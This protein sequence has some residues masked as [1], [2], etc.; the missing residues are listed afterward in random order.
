MTSLFDL[1]G[2]TVLVTGGNGGLGLAFAT[3]CARHG[4]NI[5]IWGR[6]ARKNDEAVEVL[7]GYGVRAVGYVV[8]VT[9]EDVVDEAMDVVVAAFGRIDCVFANAGITTP[10][11][12]TL[13]LSTQVYH[14]LLDIN[15]H[16]AYYTLRAAA[17]HMVQQAEAG[18][19][20]GSLVACGSLAMFRAVPGIPHYAAAKAALAA[21]VRNLAVELARYRIR[22]NV[23]APGYFR[24]ELNHPDWEEPF[25]A[26]NPMGR[27]GLP[28]DLEG[29]AVYLASDA[30]SYHTGDTLVLDG[31]TMA[32]L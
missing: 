6:S 16:G 14:N 10:A 31:G 32:R 17:R 19:G 20:G 2:K 1:T 3:G 21:I 15:L 26:T 22:A 23:I 18:R 12:S 29:I 24:T 4:A 13:E 11:P 9:R 7:A 28:A 25:A 8:D 27:V 30:S 5:A